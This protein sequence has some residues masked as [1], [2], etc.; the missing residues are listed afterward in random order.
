[1]ID[2]SGRVLDLS[3]TTIE[4]YTAPEDV[5]QPKEE[6]ARSC[7]ETRYPDP[8]FLVGEEQIT[9][10]QAEVS[11][12]SLDFGVRKYND[13]IMWGSRVTDPE[14]WFHSNKC[15]S[16]ARRLSGA[17]WLPSSPKWANRGHACAGSIV[18]LR[19]PSRKPDWMCT[20]FLIQDVEEL[21]WPEQ[22]HVLILEPWRHEAPIQGIH[23]EKA[24][25]DFF[26][27]LARCTEDVAAKA[28]SLK[29]LKR[30][31]RSFGKAQLEHSI[32]ACRN[33]DLVTL[34]F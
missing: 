24:R 15:A 5:V 3:P 22:P 6:V 13:L 33:L 17:G 20:G 28:I 32:A 16:S 25:R 12:L 4:Q 21:I 2:D 14:I 7:D 29:W 11:G 19:A 1:V 9:I 34:N 23:S 27:G 30:E 18:C 31:Y 8:R 26:W 10:I